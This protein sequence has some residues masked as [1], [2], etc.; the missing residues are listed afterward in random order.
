MAIQNYVDVC[1]VVHETPLIRKGEVSS[2][3]TC[4]LST[5][6]G[7]KDSE[8]VI[9]KSKF[10][11]ITEE[12]KTIREMS[13]WKALDIVRITG[14]IATKETER[15]VVCPNCGT[16]NHRSES[17][18]TARSGGTIVYIYPIYAR[19]IASFSEKEDAFQYLNDNATIA[20]RVF[21]L[22]NLTKDPE[23]KGSCTRFQVA[24]NRKYC[25]KGIP[26]ITERTDYPWIYS[27]GEN[28]EKDFAA[29]KKGSSVFVD[30]ILR[31]RNYEEENICVKCGEKIIR[32]D[33]ALEIVSFSSEYFL[34]YDYV[35]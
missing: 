4:P 22:G 14:F 19:K 1:A 5:I 21:L 27:Y 23:R 9:A 16:I 12:P 30:G 29:L 20:N 2:R 10:L 31:S 28:A 11:T 13:N 32:K 34:N 26:D 3:A 35:P 33:T 7:A 8:H 25:A 15:K 17:V 6:H 24:I 18:A